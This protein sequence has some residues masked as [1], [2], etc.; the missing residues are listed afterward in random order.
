MRLIALLAIIAL[1]VVATWL[2]ITKIHNH[3]L[4]RLV[5]DK[6]LS[7]LSRK[8]RRAYAKELLARERDEYEL[9][10]QERLARIIWNRSPREEEQ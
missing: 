10:K 4:E 2:V 1:V 9:T 3:R 7:Y 5:K 8:E 6:E